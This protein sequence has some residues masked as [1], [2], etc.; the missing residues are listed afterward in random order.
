[1]SHFAAAL[2]AAGFAIDDRWVSNQGGAG[3]R[4]YCT[5]HEVAEVI[6]TIASRLLAMVAPGPAHTISPRRD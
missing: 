3:L 5:E 1:M 6:A 4:A 2:E